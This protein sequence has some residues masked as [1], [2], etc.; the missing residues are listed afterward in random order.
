MSPTSRPLFFA[1]PSRQESATQPSPRSVT[2]RSAAL[3]GSSACPT[4]GPRATRSG[5]R[6]FTLVELLVV[7]GILSMLMALLTPAVFSARSAAMNAKVKSEI[8][9]IHMALMNY[10]SEYGSFPPADMSGL[11]LWNTNPP[12]VNT[13]H[14]AYKHLVRIFPRMTENLWEDQLR[15]G[16]SPF[17]Y[18][19]QMSPA[20]ALVFWLRGFYPNQEYPLTNRTWPPSGTRKKLFEFN[21][22]QLYAATAYLTPNGS[23]RQAFAPRGQTNDL[24][25][26]EYPVYFTSHVNS[27]LPYVYFDARCYDKEQ[28]E[29]VVFHATSRSGIATTA[30]PYWSST[31]PANAVYSQ[32]HVSPDAFQLI[33][34]GPDGSF[35]PDE[36]GGSRLLVSFPKQGAIPAGSV[37]NASNAAVPIPAVTEVGIPQSHRDNLTN[38]ASGPLGDCAETRG[39]K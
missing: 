11:W 24:F 21:E 25:E 39:A 17:F 26:N 7:I 2:D 6:G 27:G 1:S 4:Q 29:D 16:P 12:R 22:T 36:L 3:T 32:Y 23:V 30:R 18:M 31:R 20:Q 9:M 37:Y 13:S 34:S 15:P 19:A 28:Y 10:K 8:D 5:G 33:A 38:F 35:G 14:P